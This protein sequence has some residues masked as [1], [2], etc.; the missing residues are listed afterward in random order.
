MRIRIVV[1][2]LLIS[3]GVAQLALAD[4]PESWDEIELLDGR[5]LSGSITREGPNY[6]V[7]KGM[8]STLVPALAVIRV[9]ELKDPLE[10]Y[11]QAK[12]RAQGPADRLRVAKLAESLGLRGDAKDTYRRILV[13]EPDNAQA[14]A[15]LGFVKHRGQ[16]LTHDEHQR[17]LGKIKFRGAWVTPAERQGVLDAEAEA[18]REAAAERATP[19]PAGGVGSTRTRVAPQTSEG[20]SVAGTQTRKR[21]KTDSYDRRTYR[22]VIQLGI[23]TPRRRRSSTLRPAG[24]YYPYG[25]PQGTYQPYSYPQQGYQGSRQRG[26]APPRP[27]TAPPRPYTA[28]PRRDPPRPPRSSGYS[29]PRQA[30]R[31]AAQPANA[32]PPSQPLAPPRQ[33]LPPGAR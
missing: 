2:A 31:R 17:A 9:R 14:R 22:R 28:P 11:E 30:A 8:G 23:S 26:Y 32:R 29:C 4:G 16:W 33:A 18:R 21:K 19:A 12:A 1:W 7:R 5:V 24:Y 27:Y 10:V 3:A 15:A 20:Q 6:R 13:D 25:Y